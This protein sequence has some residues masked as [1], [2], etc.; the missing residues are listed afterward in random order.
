MTKRRL[1]RVSYRNCLDDERRA[2]VQKITGPEVL[3]GV[4]DFVTRK[5]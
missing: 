4:D 3:D 2:L 5:K 1:R